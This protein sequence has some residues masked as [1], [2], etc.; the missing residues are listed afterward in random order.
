M[1][2]AYQITLNEQQKRDLA[3]ARDHHAKSHIRVKA[4][5]VL[6]GASGMSLR[7]VALEG[8]LKPV[9]E[10]TVSRWVETYQREGIQGWMV[11]TGR[12]RKPAFSPSRPR[13]RASHQSSGGNASS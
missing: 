6:K 11:K 7:A 8:L 3:H 5:A 4:A 12:G 9:A 2:Q 10:E 1:A 13:K